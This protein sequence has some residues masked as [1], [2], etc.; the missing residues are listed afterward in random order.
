MFLLL[1]VEDALQQNLTGHLSL[2]PSLNKRFVS[3]LPFSHLH[4]HAGDQTFVP[5]V[6]RRRQVGSF[7]RDKVR[8]R[9]LVPGGGSER[10]QGLQDLL[11]T[12]RS[13]FKLKVSQSGQEAADGEKPWSGLHI[14][15]TMSPRW[16]MPSS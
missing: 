16:F 14:C 13:K 10:G 11:W 5:P 12:L 15:L 8:Q 9:P 4:L 2:H 6:H 7:R 3:L 1:W